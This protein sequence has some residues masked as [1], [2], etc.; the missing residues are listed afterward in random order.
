MSHRLG[1]QVDHVLELD[2][3]TGAGQLV[4][5]SRERN[6]E[7]FRM[8]LAGLGQCGII[9]RARLR[10]IPAPEHVEMCALTYDDLTAFL[11]DQ[12]RL[13]SSDALGPLGGAVTTDT[14]GRWRFVLFAGTW[15]Q[16]MD[17]GDRTPAWRP[18]CTTSP[19]N[20]RHGSY[21]GTTSIAARRASEPGWRVAGR[22]RP[23]P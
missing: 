2:V 20:L 13:A 8:A 4:T 21:T 14:S 11:S 6:E 5:C 3:I 16:R 9:V 15:L 19:R 23:L 1:A 18:A 10:L 7:L 12:R 17:A 22:T